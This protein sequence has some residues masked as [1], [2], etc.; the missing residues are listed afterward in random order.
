MKIEYVNVGKEDVLVFSIGGL[1]TSEQFARYRKIIKT[2]LEIAG[3][4]ETKFILLDGSAEMAVLS[5]V[6]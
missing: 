6:G 5:K 3:L 4:G 2:N 1:L